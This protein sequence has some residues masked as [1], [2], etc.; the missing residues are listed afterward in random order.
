MATVRRLRT[1][2]R[3]VQCCSSAGAVPLAPDDLFGGAG[4]LDRLGDEYKQDTATTKQLTT[5]TELHDQ[6]RRLGLESKI[7]ELDEVGW[8][9]IEGDAALSEELTERLRVRILQIAEPQLQKKRRSGVRFAQCGSLLYHGRE[10]EEA[11]QN[12]SHMALLEYLCGGVYTIWQYL[13]SVR[14]QGTNGLPVHQDLGNGFREPY[15][16]IPQMCTSIF[17]TDPFEDG[18]GG[19][20]VCPGTHHLRRGPRLDDP[21]D[22]DIVVDTA[23]PVVAPPGSII[24]LLSNLWHGSLPRRIPGERVVCSCAVTRPHYRSSDDYSELPDEI[25]ARNPPRFAKLVG[26]NLGLMDSSAPGGAPKSGVLFGTARNAGVLSKF[27][28]E[29]QDYP[30]LDPY[31]RMEAALKRKTDDDE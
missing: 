22:R 23:T 18:A 10:F 27:T 7:Q 2:V 25:L 1:A 21:S 29:E 11:C 26:R 20:F 15:S 14:G 12:E 28:R 19:T 4:F 8:T 6:I 13:A 17:V 24:V 3:G 5:R 30:A 16:K 9:L 31:R